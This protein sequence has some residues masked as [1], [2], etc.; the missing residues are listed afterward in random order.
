MHRF[1][2]LF[3]FFIL[4]WV[5]ASIYIPP[6]YLESDLPDD[7]YLDISIKKLTNRLTVNF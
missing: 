2:Y 6:K 7:V 3:I 4:C 5:A 1:I